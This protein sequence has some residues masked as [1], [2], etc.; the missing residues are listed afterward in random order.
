MKKTTSIPSVWSI[1]PDD[2]AK[3]KLAY[4]SYLAGD[5]NEKIKILE[6][7][8]RQISDIPETFT[9]EENGTAIMA[10]EGVIMP[11]V[12]LFSLLFGGA[13]LDVLTRDFKA[14]IANDSV[15]AIVLDVDSPG[16]VVFRVQEFANMVFESRNIKP[17]FAISSSMM[18]SAAQYIASAAEQI[19]ITDNSVMSGSIGVV[20]EHIDISELERKIGIKTSEIVAGKYKRI[21]S[22]FGPLTEEGRQ[23]LQQQID[24]IYNSFVADVAKFRGSSVDTVLSSMADGKLFVGSQGIDVGL[25]DGLESLDSLVG[26]IMPEAIRIKSI[27]KLST[28]GFENLIQAAKKDSTITPGQVAV[29][30]INEMKSN[31][32]TNNNYKHNERVGQDMSMNIEKFKKVPVA[33]NLTIEQ[34]LKNRWDRDAE[35]KQEFKGNFKAFLAFEKNDLKSELIKNYSEKHN[36]S[37]YE[38]QK[39]I[40]LE[41]KSNADMAQTDT[42]EELKAEWNSNEILRREFSCNFS[43]YC[44]YMKNEKAGRAKVLGQPVTVN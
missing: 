22:S 18:T 23:D 10:I 35:L 1:L 17:I 19:F 15:E 16:G 33:N 29:K 3:L 2:L 4:Q 34:T 37:V 6:G 8:D 44:A 27:N 31:T 43:A 36:I 13:T 9:I 11:K 21:A 30:I 20:A 25:V 14:L 7:R 41:C 26:D 38:A 39:R 42:T 5:Y 24:H 40:N 32:H 12:N 28:P